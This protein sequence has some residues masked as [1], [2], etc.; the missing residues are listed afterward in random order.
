MQLG[1]GRPGL[2]AA[3]DHTRVWTYPRGSYPPAGPAWWDRFLAAITPKA[4]FLLYA[5]DSVLPHAEDPNQFLRK[6]YVYQAMDV[7]LLKQAIDGMGSKWEFSDT[8]SQLF[9]YLMNTIVNPFKNS[10]SVVG[11][12]DALATVYTGIFGA[13]KAAPVP[14]RVVGTPKVKLVVYSGHKTRMT[15]VDSAYFRFSSTQETSNGAGQYV[16]IP[17]PDGRTDSAYHAKYYLGEIK[18][19]EQWLRPR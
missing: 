7:G 11:V 10:Q 3:A 13:P 17:G 12:K 14:E 19:G 8:G 15:Q 5:P 2:I 1:D 4:G 6:G 18:V 16:A 9:D